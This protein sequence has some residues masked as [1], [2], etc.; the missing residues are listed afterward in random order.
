MPKSRRSIVVEACALA[1]LPSAADPESDGR[2][3]GDVEEVSAAQVSVT[4]GLV[5]V[6]RARVDHRLD[7]RARHIP[8]VQ[9]DASGGEPERAVDVRHGEIF[10][11][12]RD[13]GRRRIEL[14]RRGARTRA[15]PRRGE[16]D[17]KECED[18]DLEALFGLS[19]GAREGPVVELSG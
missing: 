12:K 17:G 10:D 3:A 15:E 6:D 13:P 2:V 16:R 5:R 18:R 9:Y 4:L 8:V 19:P 11:R 1:R 14:P 7:R